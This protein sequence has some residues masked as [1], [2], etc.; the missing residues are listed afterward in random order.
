MPTI[1]TLI[2]AGISA[3]ALTVL[4]GIFILPEKR[5]AKNNKIFRILSDIFTFK[6]LLL[7][8][9]ITYLYTF[10]TIA[11]VVTGVLL[12]ITV[13]YY[14]SPWSGLNLYYRGGWGL[15]ILVGGP[16]AVRILFEI[17]MMFVLLVQNT[18]SINNKLSAITGEEEKTESVAA[19]TAAPEYQPA[20]MFCTYCGTQYDA[21]MGGCPNC[22]NQQQFYPYQQQ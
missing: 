3:I 16:I 4:A 19:E 8:K 13:D 9:I 20:Y 6:D 14:D 17:S 12:L 1:A 22:S 18:I 7:G 15:I 10:C 2:I 21:N 11:C 5:R